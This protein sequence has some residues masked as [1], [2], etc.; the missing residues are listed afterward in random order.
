MNL[1]D[2]DYPLPPELIAQE[3]AP[4]RDQSRLMVLNRQKGTILHDRFCNLPEYLKPE[5]TVVLND[6]KVWPARLLGKKGSGGKV[7]V[8]LI[9]KADWEPSN[10]ASSPS[11]ED[12]TEEWDCLI[13]N[14]GRLRPRTGLFFAEE[15]DGEVLGKVKEG[16]WRLRLR[17]QSGLKDALNR[18]GYP[19]LPPYIRRNGREDYKRMDLD[20]YQTIYAQN[21]GAIAAPTAGLHFTEEVLEKIRGRK[22]RVVFLTLHVG[23]GTFLP[24]RAER[25]E[26][27]RLEPEWFDL[28]AETA[29]TVNRTKGLGGR[30][31]AVGTTVV[32]TLE[33]RTDGNE[34]V[35][36]GTGRTGL[37][38]LPGHRFQVVDA[39]LTNFHLP[40]STL[41]MLVSA[42]AGR[43]RILAA[44]A[45]AV[46]ERYRFFSY[47]D[48]MLII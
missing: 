45:E 29:A 44:Y 32:R 27:H 41:L 37:F 3:P 16:F 43:E 46:K 9:R 42:F 38:I 8:L 18:I 36:P 23:V 47:G 30:V 21:P 35:Q 40:R 22:T 19:P 14:P 17:R 24:V 13:Q 10:G 31:V 34:L 25:I 12:E 2:F 7:E 48:A 1:H 11:S 6:T 4:A 20:R 33:S 28:P 15:V 39:M 26:N 5:D